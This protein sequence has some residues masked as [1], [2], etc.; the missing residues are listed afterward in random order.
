MES[1]TPKSSDRK[2]WVEMV[3]TNGML[4]S[5]LLMTRFKR[6]K[7]S[8]S[9]KINGNFVATPLSCDVTTSQVSSGLDRLIKSKKVR[10][11]KDGLFKHQ[12]IR[13]VAKEKGILF[14]DD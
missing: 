3:R 14:I 7:F 13:A 6:N 1:D 4:N 2:A 11:E 9:S 5:I 12:F 10:Y 8:N